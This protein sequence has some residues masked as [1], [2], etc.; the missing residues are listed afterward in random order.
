MEEGTTLGS[1]HGGHDLPSIALGP[2]YLRF[3]SQK[4]SEFVD[5]DCYIE[6][7]RKGDFQQ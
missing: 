6:T 7:I 5:H 4:N 3:D 1:D 2:G